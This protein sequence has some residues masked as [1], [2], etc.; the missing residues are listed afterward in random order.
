MRT[1]H[2]EHCGNPV[3]FENTRCTT[4]RH[5]LGVVPEVLRVSALRPNA[6]GTWRALTRLAGD[7][8]Y[9]K[10]ENYHV[11]DVC[12][13]LVTADSDEPFCIGTIRE[14]YF[15]FSHTM[16]VYDE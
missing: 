3:Y 5:E 6:D 4:C 15:G 10:C 7:R 2:C 1:F 13:W 16:T 12:N 11:H 8:R 14:Q 9:R